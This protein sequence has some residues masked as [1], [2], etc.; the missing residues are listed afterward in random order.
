MENKENKSNN[1]KFFKKNHIVE[2]QE[3]VLDMNS[4]QNQKI[5][6]LKLELLQNQKKINDIELRKLADIENIKKNIEEKIRKIK[7]TEIERF[8]KTIIPVI[9]SLEEILISSNTSTIKDESVIKGIELILQ[10]LLNILY[11]IGVKIEGQKNELFN[12]EIH[13]LISTESSKK[14]APNHIVFTH[15]KGFTFNKVLLR[16]ATVTISKN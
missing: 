14:I 9:D 8:L 5:D 3:K 6:N 13:T 10:S 4:I 16:K 12:P 1:E 2:E 15:K 7:K 11:K